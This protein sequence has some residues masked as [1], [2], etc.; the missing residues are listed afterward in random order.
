MAMTALL[1]ETENN[2][3]TS[4]NRKEWSCQSKLV[5][6]YTVENLVFHFYKIQTRLGW[7]SQTEKL[8]IT[9]VSEIPETAKTTTTITAST[10]TTE[11]NSAKSEP[12]DNFLTKLILIIF[13]KLL[14]K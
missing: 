5:S 13:S 9:I 10:T 3:N 14:I 2:V 11:A 8:E 7:F 6:A 4:M 1:N 12:S